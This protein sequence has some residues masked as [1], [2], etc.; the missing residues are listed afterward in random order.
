MGAQPFPST[1]PAR[2]V[3]MMKT[4]DSRRIRMWRLSWLRCPIQESPQLSAPPGLK[5]EPPASERLV[6]H[7][8]RA[9]PV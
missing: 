9:C 4:Q 8:G 3:T 6:H 2:A 7:S 1:N 5:P